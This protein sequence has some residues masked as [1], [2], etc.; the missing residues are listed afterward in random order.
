MKKVSI[1]IPAYNE[2][3]T[4]RLVLEEVKKVVVN[5]NGYDFEV[6]VVNDHSTDNTSQIAEKYNNVT[7]LNNA[8]S[9]GKGNALIAGFERA[10]GDIII[11]MDADY[12]HSAEDIPEF[13]EA[14]E[15]GA[16]LVIGSRITGGSEEYTPIRALGNIFLTDL[17]NILFRTKLTDALNGYKG[18]KK[19]IVKNRRFSSKSFEIEIELISNTLKDGFKVVEIPS[20]E[21]GRAGGRLKSKAMKDGARFLFKILSEGLKYRISHKNKRWK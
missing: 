16:G 20:H 4:I 6:I 5:S 18:F 7:V 8:G 12:S 2:E 10:E 14:I 19:E 9:Q 11:M 21:R 13:I 17:L 15:R 1:V 3:E